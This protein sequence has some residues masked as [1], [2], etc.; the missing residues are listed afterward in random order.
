M[1]TSRDVPNPAALKLPLNSPLY[2][3]NTVEYAGFAVNNP[4][5]TREG[6]T[7]E[8]HGQFFSL[9]AKEGNPDWFN[10]YTAHDENAE[11]LGDITK[12]FVARGGGFKP[13]V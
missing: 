8:Q 13:A 9:T 12:A 5:A 6:V 11:I 3:G 4:Q 1:P 10:V 2:I 7:Y